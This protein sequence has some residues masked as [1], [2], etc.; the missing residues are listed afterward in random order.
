MK[1]TAILVLCL[2]VAVMS[3]GCGKKDADNPG[4]GTEGKTQEISFNDFNTKVPAN[5]EEVEQPADYEDVQS[6]SFFASYTNGN[7]DDEFFNFGMVYDTD[8]DFKEKVEF[9]EMNYE[10]M[11]P[12]YKKKELKVDGYD[13]VLLECI[14]EGE[15]EVPVG[16]AFINGPTGIIDVYLS[17][18]TREEF[19]A[20]YEILNQ[21]TFSK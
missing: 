20:L 14:Y 6:V 4:E 7:E 18:E 19:N 3:F 15:K 1:K 13:A 2:L 12:D 5:W 17:T 16:E 10:E 9:T 8:A 11:S 21:G